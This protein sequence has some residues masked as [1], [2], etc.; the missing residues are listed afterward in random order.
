MEKKYEIHNKFLLL[1]TGE[2][3]YPITALKDIPMFD[4][5][6][7]DFGGYIEH[8]YNL[9]H[10]GNA[11]IGADCIV[12]GTSIIKDDV[13]IEGRVL[14]SNSELS[15]DIRVFGDVMLSHCYLYGTKIQIKDRVR[16]TDVNI[17]GKDMLIKD[18]CVLINVYGR[19]ALDN[20]RMTGK[21]KIENEIEMNIG[22]SRIEIS[23]EA[24][25]KNVSN[26]IGNDIFIQDHAVVEENSMIHGNHVTIKDSAFITN[27]VNIED[28]VTV[29][30]CV[31]LYATKYH[32]DGIANAI[33]TGDREINVMYL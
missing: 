25:I 8:E 1:T 5:K 10:S 29:S 33:F 19:R 7:G 24:L 11:W 4:V 9:C 21:A 23:D 17:N 2:K 31:K 32:M 20:F 26:L 30:E 28:N 13:I 12:K 14:V 22:G 16:M 15:Q 6:V 18:D 3:V 27:G